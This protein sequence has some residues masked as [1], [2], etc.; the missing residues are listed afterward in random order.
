MIMDR[1][2]VQLCGQV[3]LQAAGESDLLDHRSNL[4]DVSVINR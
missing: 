1:S 3:N 4:I 2:L